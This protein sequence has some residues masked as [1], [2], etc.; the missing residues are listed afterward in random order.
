MRETE[1]REGA[2]ALFTPMLNE[3]SHFPSGA[4]A[5]P[6]PQPAPPS[7]RPHGGHD[8]GV[9]SA[10]RA[11]E[12]IELFAVHRHPL[13]VTEIADA[14][15]IPQS[16]S[17]VLL[18][19][20]SQ[21]G[22][23]ARDRRTRKY[24]PSI[25]SVFLGNWIHDTL[26]REGSLLRALDTLSLA[27]D[28]NV[29]LGVRNGI[30][31]QYVHVSWP[32]TEP[33]RQHLAPGMMMPICH[34]GLGR[35]LLAAEGEAE[36]RSIVRHANAIGDGPGAVNVEA[37]MPSLRRHRAAGFAECDDL[38]NTGERVL[39]VPLPA[40]FDNPVAIGLGVAADRLP[41]ERPA[42]LAMLETRVKDAWGM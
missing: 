23:I 14:L 33:D 7:A 12:I 42:L 34:D 21:A 25:R 37:F 35:I 8:G 17:S 13:S 31:V 10:T 40:R 11:L 3:T 2:A 15:A 41:A 26:F 27:A 4:A 19:A 6:H 32:R 20:M 22:F 38:E 28:A 16:S 9:K 1:T 39:A 24:M 30:H 18:Q 5:R 29:R 36:A